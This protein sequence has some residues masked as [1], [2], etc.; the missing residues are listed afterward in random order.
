ME[1]KENQI[2]TSI[3]NLT[4]DILNLEKEK[5]SLINRLKTLNIELSIFK[6]LKQK[7]EEVL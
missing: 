7:C 1:K 6:N 5:K 2:K 4:K 3:K